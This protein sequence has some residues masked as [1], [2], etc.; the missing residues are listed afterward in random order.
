MNIHLYI[1]L[2]FSL[3]AS[4]SAVEP[5]NPNLNPSAR[6][7]LDYLALVYQKKMLSGYNVYVHTNV[8]EACG[9]KTGFLAQ[10]WHCPFW[11][12]QVV[13]FLQL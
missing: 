6:K 10:L 2:V 5:V 1:L 4:A 11:P 7:V 13:W 9:A 8:V 3:A 12:H